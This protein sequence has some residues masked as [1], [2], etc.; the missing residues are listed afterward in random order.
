MKNPAIEEFVSCRRIAVVGASRGG[1]KFG[2]VAAKE[3]Q[4]AAIR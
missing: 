4:R 1:K 2:N 3:L